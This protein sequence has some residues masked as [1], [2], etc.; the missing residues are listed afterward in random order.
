MNFQTF[1]KNISKN[2]YFAT[3]RFDQTYSCENQRFKQNN[4]WNSLSIK[5]QKSLT[6]NNLFFKKDN[7]DEMQL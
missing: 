5:R 7:I 3:F 1:A 2:I 4:K 6:F